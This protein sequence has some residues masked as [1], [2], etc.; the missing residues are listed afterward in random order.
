MDFFGKT[1]KEKLE[2]NTEL[3][4]NVASNYDKFFTQTLNGLNL[5]KSTTKEQPQESVRLSMKKEDRL[6]HNEKKDPKRDEQL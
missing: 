1:A 4:S 6:A 3:Q 2:L 5:K